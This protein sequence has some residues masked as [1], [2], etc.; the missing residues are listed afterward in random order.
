MVLLIAC[1]LQIPILLVKGLIEDRKELS[2]N[3]QTEL[4]SSWGGLL[5]I[6]VPELCVPF[7]VNSTDKDGKSTKEY[8]VERSSHLRQQSMFTLMWK[9]F[10]AQSMRFLSIRLTSKWQALSRPMRM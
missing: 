5:D 6:N 2:N 10:I 7:Y 3:V 9:Y 8:K 1:C 4:T